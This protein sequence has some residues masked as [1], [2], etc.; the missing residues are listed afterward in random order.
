M[1]PIKASQDMSFCVIFHAV[2]LIHNFSSFLHSRKVS[3]QS[4]LIF[5]FKNLP[6]DTPTNS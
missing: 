2:T 6:H 1:D 3:A 5:Y 4:K